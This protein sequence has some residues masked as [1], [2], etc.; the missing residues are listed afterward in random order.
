VEVE[1]IGEYDVAERLFVSVELLFV[2]LAVEVGA[3][4]FRLD[5]ADWDVVTC[6]DVV[7]R[8]AVGAFGLVGDLDGIKLRQLLGLQDVLQQRFQR[9]AVAVFGSVARL[10]RAVEVGG[11]FSDFGGS[12]IRYPLRL[13]FFPYKNIH[14]AACR[15]QK[16]V[17]RTGGH[18]PTVAV[19]SWES[20]EACSI[21]AAIARPVYGE[22]G[23]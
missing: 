5:V 7:G 15:L 16:R 4:V 9:G 11:I 1:V 21:P 2:R 13:V 12:H 17:A 8:S 20:K 3:N 18:S 10:V 6:G 19:F 14:S 22:V 23:E